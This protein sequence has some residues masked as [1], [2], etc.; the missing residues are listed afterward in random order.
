[1]VGYG[2]EVERTVDGELP[3]RCPVL[4]QRPEV[5]GLAH[6]ETVRILWHCADAI[7]DRIEGVAGVYMQ[8]T[9]QRPTQRR[10]VQARFP[11]FGVA[12]QP[13]FRGWR[14]TR[15]GCCCRPHLAPS[16]FPSCRIALA[17][18]DEDH[19]KPQQYGDTNG[20]DHADTSGRVGGPYHSSHPGGPRL[21]RDSASHAETTKT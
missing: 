3:D 10:V 1:M 13:L 11:L 17:A 18:A 14:G 19:G 15:G 16:I 2:H 5:D 20:L 21:A 6:R 12:H 8:V 4:I 9:E 7:S